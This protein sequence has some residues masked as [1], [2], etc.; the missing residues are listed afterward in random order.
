[1]EMPEEINRILTDRISDLL[2]CPTDT[3][4]SNLNKEGFSNFPVIIEKHGDINEGCG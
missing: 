2:S 3:A 4:I 1:M